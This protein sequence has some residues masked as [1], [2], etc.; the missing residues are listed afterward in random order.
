MATTPP[1]PSPS[2]L[3]MPPAP[4]H[5]A[6][7]YSYEPY[8][9]RH[10][11]RLAAQRAARDSQTTP[12]PP[13]PSGLRARA[14]LAGGRKQ[15]DDE[16]GTLSPPGSIQ[17]SP[18]K[19]PSGRSR[20]VVPSH[21]LDN[22]TDLDGTNTACPEETTHRKQSFLQ[23]SRTTTVAGMLPTPAK[24]PRKKA[25]GDVSSTARTLFPN[26][27]SS[28]PK[29]ARKYTG[30]S[31]ESF[32]ED[33]S[34]N[35][36]KIEIFTDSRDR[37]PELDESEGNPFYSKPGNVEASGNAASRTSK[38]RKADERKRDKDVEEA[39]KR[40]DGMIYVL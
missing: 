38:R 27:A 17:P 7:Y 32:E 16:L 2:T 13:S 28:R 37:I 25:V 30:F 29:K 19:K 6:G 24:T 18:R 39:I 14:D 34:D 33:P 10:S 35:H 3:R 26:P 5:G 15:R 8:A 4:R 36:K 11:A 31:L 1:P 23:A 12:P 22:T 21:S 9:T 40:D 20:G